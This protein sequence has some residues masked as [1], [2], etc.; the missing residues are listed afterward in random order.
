M[1]SI[2]MNIVPSYVDDELAI[3]FHI[4]F[5]QYSQKI[6]EAKV[7]TY[8]HGKAG[9]STSRTAA[10]SANQKYG[11]L[12]EFNVIDEYSQISMNKMR[13]FLKIIGISN[14]DQA[15]KI[16]NASAT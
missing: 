15:T 4:E 3:V 11:V 7:Y 10:S 12:K 13:H 8:N 5:T 1:N 16:S 6:G 2:E 9:E 14:I